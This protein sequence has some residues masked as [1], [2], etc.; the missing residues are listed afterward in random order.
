MYVFPFAFLAAAAGTTS[1]AQTEYVNPHEAEEIGE[2]ERI[3]SGDL[4]PDLAV[5]TFRNIHRLFPT[6]TV[7]AGGTARELPSSERQ[8]APIEADIDGQSY[9]LDDFLALNQVTG[10][11]VLKDGA[12]VYETYQRG[13][14]P[15]TRWMSM[16]VVK[17]ITSTLVG[18]ALK[19]GHI[20]SLD[21][22]VADYVP[23]LEGSAYDGASIKDILLMASGASWD[24]TYTDPESDRRDLLRAQL[25]QEQGALME[26]MAGLNR[27][28]EPG[29]VHTYSTGET[30]VLSEVVRGAVDKSVATYLSEKIW[31]PYGME[32][33]AE[34]WLDAPDGH[35]IG[36]SGLSATLR[37]YARFGQFFLE[38]GGDVLPEGWTETAGQPQELETGEPIA[39]G[40]MWWPAWTDASKEDDAFAAVGIQGQYVYINPAE[41]VVIAVTGAQPEP[42]GKEPVEPMAFFDAVVAAIE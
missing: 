13:N 25:A 26:V 33:D 40:Y 42:L 18:A 34:W 38:G 8:L 10:M 31:T 29:I 4:P 23:A 20:G 19:D 37:D 39:Y 32:T 22:N 1:L 2:V 7:E 36:G 6:A 9:D 24:E 27:G 5:S 21:D 16:S 15:E 17:S 12:V 30:Q 14:T 28:A 11:L 35:V 41:N 3:Y